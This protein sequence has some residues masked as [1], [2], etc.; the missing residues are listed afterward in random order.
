MSRVEKSHPSL[1]AEVCSI[2]NDLTGNTE[3]DDK[4][5][6]EFPSAKAGFA[7]FKN[8]SG[9]VVDSSIHR[10]AMLLISATERDRMRLNYMD[11]DGSF[12][13]AI[14]LMIRHALVCGTETI[15]RE[16]F[17]VCSILFN[18]IWIDNNA[19]KEHVRATF[20]DLIAIF[21]EDVVTSSLDAAAF[22]FF[23]KCMHMFADK[24]NKCGITMDEF[25]PG[26]FVEQI[27]GGNELVI[28]CLAEGMKHASFAIEQEDCDD[29]SGDE[30]DDPFECEEACARIFPFMPILCGDCLFME[31]EMLSVAVTA[32]LS[33]GLGLDHLIRTFGEIN[34]DSPSATP[35]LDFLVF[36]DNRG[37]EPYLIAKVTTQLLHSDLC[38]PFKAHEEACQVV[39]KHALDYAERG[40]LTT[41]MEIALAIFIPRVI[42]I[43]KIRRSI[44]EILFKFS[45]IENPEYIENCADLFNSL[46]GDADTEDSAFIYDCVGP[47]AFRIFSVRE[48][49]SSLTTALFPTHILRSKRAA[50]RFLREDRENRISVLR[51]CLAST[52]IRCDDVRRVFDYVAGQAGGGCDEGEHCAKKARM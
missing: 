6:A 4:L 3:G 18:L 30:D 43:S 37:A 29:D 2:R 8:H 5:N 33:G 35:Y 46:L 11:V 20:I 13:H 10:A 49:D 1:W 44:C 47:C 15:R 50:N 48:N 9:D 34:V 28:N 36:L 27:R 38:S 31:P 32:G 17:S 21:P 25:K 16:L 12:I 7:W 41:T 52:T 23:L 24:N 45:E 14:R 19:L 39:C 40:C 51:K 26:M 22:V 42:S